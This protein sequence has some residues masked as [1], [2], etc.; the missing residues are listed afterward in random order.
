M[1]LVPQLAAKPGAAMAKVLEIAKV[2]RPIM[3]AG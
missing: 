3:L 2:L 1:L